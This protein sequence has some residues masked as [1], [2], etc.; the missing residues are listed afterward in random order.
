MNLGFEMLMK[1]GYKPGQGIGKTESGRSEPIPMD[2]KTNRLGLGKLNPTRKSTKNIN[3]IAKLEGLKTD[4]FR[5][6]MAAKKLEQL[7]EVDLY[8]SQK[9]CQQLDT[10]NNIKEP[11][12]TW[13]WPPV[14]KEKTNDDNEQ[15]ENE[16]KEESENEDDEFSTIEK[17]ELLTKY[18]RKNYNYCIWCGATYDNDDDLKDNCPGSTRNDH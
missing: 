16:D 5:G 12:E 11:Y 8:N 7:A 2:L 1:M 3:P 6:R 10:A 14:K 15:E 17:L 4:D 13:H 18:L 9:V